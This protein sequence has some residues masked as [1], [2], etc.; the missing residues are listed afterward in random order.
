VIEA[1][2]LLCPV[3]KERVRPVQGMNLTRGQENLKKVTQSVGF[4]LRPPCFA[5][6]P[7][8]R[9]LFFAFLLVLGFEDETESRRILAGTV[10]AS[11]GVEAYVGKRLHDII[12]HARS[13]ETHSILHLKGFGAFGFILRM[14][15]VRKPGRTRIAP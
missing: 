4:L 8:L 6:L 7:D 13:R 10:A 1:R 14:V 15:V 5:R 2:R 11:R 3:M 9:R 12:H